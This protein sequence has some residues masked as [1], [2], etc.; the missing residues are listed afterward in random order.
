MGVKRAHDHARQRGIV[1]ALNELIEA[2]ALAKFNVGPRRIKQLA[3]YL[4]N[5]D[6]NLF[7]ENGHHDH[8]HIEEPNLKLEDTYLQAYGQK[9]EIAA[10]IEDFSH[11][12]IF[13]FIKNYHLNWVAPECGRDAPEVQQIMLDILFPL[14]PHDEIWSQ[15]CAF[16]PQRQPE[17][18][19]QFSRQRYQWAKDQW[20]NLSGRIT[21][22][23]TL[24]DF[25]L[26]PKEIDIRMVISVA[27]GKQFRQVKI[28]THLEGDG[29]HAEKETIE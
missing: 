17:S 23:W 4:Y 18:V 2:G 6:T 16:T 19:W 10:R 9:D 12:G 13:M 22:I 15:Y 8:E 3:Y 25:N 26:L 29:I 20:P 24:Q 5:I 28:H 1:D 11:F 27:D 14:T 7:S 21:T